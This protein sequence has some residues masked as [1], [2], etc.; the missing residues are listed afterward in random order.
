MPAAHNAAF[1]DH[2]GHAERTQEQWQEANMRGENFDPS[3]W[4][5]AFDGDQPAGALL[6]FKNA[7]KSWVRGLGV[8]R[9]WRRRGL[10]TA[11]LLHAF[12]EFYRRG[13]WPALVR[14]LRF[15]GDPRAFAVLGLELP[16]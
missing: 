1:A 2:W 11:L 14:D 10:A 16:H 8:L 12:G 15:P 3:L 7:E 4:F 6:G 5:L 13:G 9:P